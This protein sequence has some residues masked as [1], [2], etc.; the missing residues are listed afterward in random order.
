MT[1]RCGSALWPAG[2]VQLMMG[3]G[4]LIQG[5]TTIISYLENLFRISGSQIRVLHEKFDA[6]Y[7]TSQLEFLTNMF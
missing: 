3:V 4:P 7:G 5:D 6:A 2:G 1:D